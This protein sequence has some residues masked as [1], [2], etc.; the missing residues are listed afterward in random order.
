MSKKNMSRR[1]FIG[2]GAAGASALA[3]SPALLELLLGATGCKSGPPDSGASSFILAEDIL[4]KAVSQLMARGADFGDVFV[5]R[6]AIDSVMSDDRKINT[7]TT[8]E[9]GVGLRAVK[10]G[11]T[12]YAYTDSF[13]PDR[14]YETARYVA[15]A[16]AAPAA[17]TT[18]PVITLA[19]LA[20]ALSFPIKPLP[21]EIAVDK[22]IELFKALTDRAWSAD[23]R[24]VQAI[25][26]LREILRQVTIATSSGK[27][28]NQT[29]G[30]TEFIAQTYVKGADGGLQ[31]AWDQR[32]AYAGRD[33]F[34]GANAFEKIVDAAGAKAVKLLEAVDSPRGVF[35]VVLGPGVNGV[36][37][38]E[39][40]G[41]GMEGDLVFKG[42]NYKDQI[43]KQTAARGVTLIDDGTVPS[44]PGSFAFDDEGTP[45]ERTVLI[46]DGIQ[47]NYLCDVIYGG[48][49]GL[50][51]TGNGRRQSFRYP[52]IPRMRNTFI[53]KGPVP[54]ADIVAG[55]KRGVYVA[56]VSGGG[57]VDVITGNFMM[58][59]GEGYLI[60]NG[61]ITRP[62]KGATISGM[63]I[64]AMKSIDRIGDDLV[65][66]PSA[67]RCGKM[68]S[69]PVGFGMP[70]IRVRGILV[71]G[72][73]EAWSDIEGD[74]K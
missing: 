68:Q 23:A 52:P 49:L 22:K 9:K 66:F 62:I 56:D 48:K 13:E 64:E 57:Q 4:R 20:S 24:V 51:S 5:E 26:F 67:G 19:P 43:G 54:A 34:T 40:C 17:S 58:G 7:T 16:A 18:P 27:I 50:R 25:Q 39:S 45:S 31:A 11:R 37:F 2:R 69:A 38:H 65:M 10:G 36:L 46:E 61:K 32:G 63:G 53:D 12:F 3:F 30:L 59:V 70:T 42:S 55:T 21:S 73:G 35:P 6:A 15:D 14:I 60:E 29:L 47:K 41:H 71:G 74:K 72:K 1:S 8:I 44:F 33:F 28:V